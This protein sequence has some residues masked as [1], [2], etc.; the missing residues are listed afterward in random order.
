VPSTEAHRLLAAPYPPTNPTFSID[1]KSIRLRLPTT[2]RALAAQSLNEL[3]KIFVR[4]TIAALGATIP[5]EGNALFL[6]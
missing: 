2:I 1:L 6:A 5:Y 3:A 4:S